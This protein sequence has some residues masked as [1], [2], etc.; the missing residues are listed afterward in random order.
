MPSKDISENL[1]FGVLLGADFKLR[2]ERRRGPPPTV[3]PSTARTNFAW[4]AEGDVGIADNWPIHSAV[5]GSM[6][7][8]HRTA[9]IA[10]AFSAPEV[11][12]DRPGRRRVSRAP[13]RRFKLGCNFKTRR[14]RS[15][16]TRPP[17]GLRLP[18]LG[19]LMAVSFVRVPSC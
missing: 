13:Y 9:A 5:P 17:A 6:A 18:H 16:A 4:S 12:V 2:S 1:M 15:I 7:V 8:S 14:R 11:A 19:D 3:A 10:S